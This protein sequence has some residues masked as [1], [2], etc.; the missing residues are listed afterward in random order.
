MMKC[1]NCGQEV[2]GN[3]KICF[4]CG[5]NNPSYSPPYQPPTGYTP[6]PAGQPYSGSGY[7]PSS[8]EP[9]Q[10][11]GYQ[12]GQPPYSGGFAAPQQNASP[13]AHPMHGKAIGAFVCSLI[14][15]FIAGLILGT[16][17]LCMANTAKRNGYAG[18]LATAAKVIGT[19]DIIVYAVIIF[20]GIFA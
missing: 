19:I 5:E 13:Q 10:N 1:S 3:E 17:G 18:G 8:Y 7:N 15:F 16:I 2:F 20:I 9:T 14:G 12:N 11:Y 6:P 4:N